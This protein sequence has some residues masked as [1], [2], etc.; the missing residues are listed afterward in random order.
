[1]KVKRFKKIMDS[2]YNE[3]FKQFFDFIKGDISLKNKLKN[4]I[5]NKKFKEDVRKF[6]KEY[7]IK[8]NPKN[9]E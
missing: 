8:E 3:L 1:M 5:S 4:N 9:K 7:I 2:E 6:L